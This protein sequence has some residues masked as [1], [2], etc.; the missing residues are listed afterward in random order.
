MQ[1]WRRFGDS[2][3]LPR[4]RF[5]HRLAAAG[6]TTLATSGLWGACRQRQPL[7]PADRPLFT[8]TPGPMPAAR[9]TSSP[10]LTE[11]PREGE[12]QLPAPRTEGSMS[13]EEALSRRRSL[14]S[15]YPNRPV[16][17]HDLA[18]LFWAAQ[19][20]TARWGGRTAPS[21]GALYPL[22]LY[23]ATD[24]QVW[25]Y[26]VDR[27]HAEAIAQEDI[28]DALWEAG[29]HQYPLAMAPVIFVMTAI[30]QRTAR[31]YGDRSE[32]YVKLEA[33]H[34]AENLLLQAVALGLGAVVVGAFYD[35]QVA[36][37]LRLPE[38]EQPLYL[39]P[40]GHPTQ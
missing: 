22:E 28:R 8:A 35:E 33:G 11:T 21:A 38:D 18:Q 30:F 40:V 27:H 32:R 16:S 20:E 26:L 5:L 12:I 10:A 1:P 23:A 2:M 19:G 17:L 37:A 3:K 4:R 36:A 13:L 15:Y 31:K 6:I 9:A 24:R 14:R 25:H 39:I 7:E 34:A 29:L